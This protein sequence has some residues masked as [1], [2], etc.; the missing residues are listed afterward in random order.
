MHACTISTNTSSRQYMRMRLIHSKSVVRWMLQSTSSCTVSRACTSV[1]INAPRVSRSCV[2][3]LPRTRSVRSSKS[4]LF[5]SKY[6]GTL[7]PL[8]ASSTSFD[9]TMADTASTTMAGH[10]RAHCGRSDTA[11]SFKDSMICCRTLLRM[12]FSTTPS[13][14]STLPVGDMGS[15]KGTFSF[16]LEFMAVISRLGEKSRDSMA[17]K[18]LRK[19]GC[20]ARGFLV[21]LR[22]C[23]NSSL[24]KKKKRAKAKRLVSR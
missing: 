19:C 11:V 4:L 12:R 14:C 7:A 3:S 18:H 17:S 2:L 1:V 15:S 8:M 16:S 10:E 6:F 22:I 24:D 5:F 20:T 9:H 13:H 23:S 21:W